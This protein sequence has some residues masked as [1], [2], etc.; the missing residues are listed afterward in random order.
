MKCLSSVQK[1][2]DLQVNIFETNVRKHTVLQCNRPSGHNALHTQTHSARRGA[3]LSGASLTRGGRG[4]SGQWVGSLPWR[5]NGVTY[6][7]SAP[8]PVL[9][10]AEG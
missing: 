6:V 1:T 9:R 10:L 4:G 3:S 7:V 2:S 8:G 5:G